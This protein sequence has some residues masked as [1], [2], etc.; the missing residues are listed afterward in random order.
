MLRHAVPPAHAARLPVPGALLV[1][2][3]AVPQRLRQLER[4]VDR[5]REHR[6]CVGAVGQRRGVVEPGDDRRV[7]RRG[8]GERRTRQP[9]LGGVGDRA[10]GA[11]LVE[12][13]LI[14][15]GIDDDADVGVVLRG[16]ADHRRPTDVDQLDARLRAERIQVDDDEIDRLDAVGVH[17][18]PMIVERGI[19]EDAA[20]DLRMQRD[21]PMSEDRRHAR[22]LDHVGDLDP[23]VGDR[24]RGAAARHELPAEFAQA[25]RE[26]DDAGL[27]EHGEQSGGHAPNV[28]ST[29]RRRAMSHRRAGPGDGPRTGRA[30]DYGRVVARH[31]TA[32]ALPEVLLDFSKFKVHDWLM[33]G[34]GVGMLI[35]GLPG[36]D[37]GVGS[38]RI[39]NE[40]RRRAVRLLLHGHHPLDPRGRRRQCSC[41]SASSAAPNN[42]AVAADLP[43]RDRSRGR[44]LGHQAGLQPDRRQGVDR[45]AGWRGRAWY[46]MILSV[47]AGIVAAVGGVHELHRLG[48][49]RERPQ[50]HEQAQGE[51]R[52]RQGGRRLATPA[53][54]SAAAPSPTR[55]L[56]TSPRS[57]RVNN[58]RTYAAH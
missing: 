12:H 55:G 2:V 28:V 20:V 39:L 52:R 58:V 29:P 49:Q 16:R 45:S 6:R 24:R 47:V 13:G 43:R 22:Q 26:L 10:L 56:I 5:R 34:G 35:L 1:R 31:R 57:E 33:I 14:V 11:D 41:C 15:G 4:E 46:G 8:V 17:V 37:R 44:P 54:S 9:P 48:R 38:G 18:G 32:L 50:G 7:V 36:L 27:V 25:E 19:G 3:L 21:H 40:S 23:G 53:C 51:L 30:R 42:S